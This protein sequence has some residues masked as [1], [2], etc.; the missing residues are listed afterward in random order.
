MVIGLEIVRKKTDAKLDKRLVE[1]VV[2]A[3][4]IPLLVLPLMIKTP[5]I[6]S[7]IELIIPNIFLT[8]LFSNSFPI[9]KIANMI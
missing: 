9:P 1:L 8:F 4:D 7:T 6:I 5:K 3:V 2:T